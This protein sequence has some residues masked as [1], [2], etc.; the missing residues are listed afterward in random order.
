MRSS[1]GDA[2]GFDTIGS[3]ELTGFLSS[4]FLGGAGGAGADGSLATAAPVSDFDGL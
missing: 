3:G 4:S 1:E 2:L